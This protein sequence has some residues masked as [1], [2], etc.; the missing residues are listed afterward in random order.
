MGQ[1]DYSQRLQKNVEPL[2]IAN[3]KDKATQIAC[4]LVHSQILL[5][6][7][8]VISFGDN[9]F[10]QLG[11]GSDTNITSTGMP[12]QIPTLDNIKSIACNHHSAAIGARG[13]LYFWGTGVFGTFF[14]P[15][16]VVD[17]DIS[18]VSVGGSFGI[19]KDKDGLL[20]TWGQN[21]YGELG[22]NDFKTRLYPHPILSLKR[23]EIKKVVC[24]G[25]FA[26]AIGPD[27]RPESAAAS[28]HK[29]EKSPFHNDSTLIKIL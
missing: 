14:E 4:G 7:G 25:S 3:L 19:A 27:K 12:I 26:V 20:W 21:S 11:L 17:S 8:K 18:E 13:E 23:K 28:P 1:G 22:L 15:R 2:E 9:Q 6:N 29:R 16:I 24:G 5:A 10:G